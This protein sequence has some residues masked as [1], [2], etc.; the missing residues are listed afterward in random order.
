MEFIPALV[1]GSYAI[2][3]ADQHG[4]YSGRI[5]RDGTPIY[6][7]IGAGPM[8]RSPNGDYWEITPSNAGASVW[9]KSRNFNS[10]GSATTPGHLTTLKTNLGGTVYAW[11]RD[12]RVNLSEGAVVAMPEGS[13]GGGF[14]LTSVEP[15]GVPAASYPV[16]SKFAR[17]DFGWGAFATAA[18]DLIR[19]RNGER[20]E[21]PNL[22]DIRT[23][24]YVGT[25]WTDTRSEQ[26]MM[27]IDDGSSFFGWDMV[28]G[29]IQ[30]RASD[31]NT[32]T[33]PD[34]GVAGDRSTVRCIIARREASNI[35]IQV[36]GS[37]VSAALT[38]AQANPKPL[39][40]G[41]KIAG[42]VWSKGDMHACL[43]LPV[44]TSAAQDT[45]IRTWANTNY[46]AVLT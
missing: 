11:L 26:P 10:V 30:A 39:S 24:V 22:T 44:A 28:L 23:L 45:T 6:D 40:V 13:G 32:I 25:I 43:A 12:A 20:M 31:G 9:T 4:R 21:T 17:P 15:S 37:R 46:G 29:T 33:Q 16:A 7:V 36:T 18:P 14:D 3:F 5:R 8:P 42:G 2:G 1:D 34:S 38:V 19:F 27:R 41:G 35:T